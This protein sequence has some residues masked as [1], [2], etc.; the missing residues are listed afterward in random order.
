MDD[1]SSHP[2]VFSSGM[3]LP[4]VSAD[5]CSIAASTAE[6]SMREVTQSAAD[7]YGKEIVCSQNDTDPSPVT[8]LTAVYRTTSLIRIEWTA[9]NDSRAFEYTYSIL[10][11]GLTSNLTRTN[12]TSPNTTAFNVTG[13]D[14]GDRYKLS[15]E[16]VTPENKTSSPREVTSTTNPSPVTGLTAVYRTINLI[17]VEWTAPND[18]R[19]FE[20][21]YRIHVTWLTNNAT[22]TNSTSPNTTAFNVTGLDPGDR[23]KLS[24]ESVTPENTT[25]SPKEVTSTTNP[26]PITGLTEVYRTTSLI[27]IEWTAPNDSRA[28]EYTY[29]ILVTGLTNNATWIQSTSP[30]TTTFNMTGLDPG[31]RYKLS[32]ESVTPENTTSSPKEVTSTTNPSPVSRLFVVNRTANSIQIKWTAPTDSRASDYKYR[33]TVA[34][35]A[36]GIN[37]TNYTSQDVTAFTV[38]NL[39]PGIQYKLSVESVTPESTL[40]TPEE[41]TN[42]TNPSPV[43]GLSLVNRTTNSLG[44]KWTAPTDT[45]ASDY[46]YKITVASVAGGDSR[47]NYTSQ[48]MTVF[49]VTNLDPGIQYKLSVESVTPESTLSIPEEVTNTTNPSP[50]F[51]LSL[52]NRTTNSLGIKWTAPT[53]T[54]ASDYKYKITVASVA[55]GDSRTNY[56]SQDMTVFTV[57]NLDPGIQYKLSVESVTPESTL[58]IPEEVTN[59]TNPSPV[60][61][62]SLVNRTTNSLGIKWTAPTDTRASDYKYKITVAS[63][64]GGDSRTNYT[65]QDMTVFTV[66]NLDPGIQYKLSVESVTP[67]STL[68]IPE[69]VT[70]TTNPSPVSS[71]SVV[72]RTTNSIQIKWTAPTDS[73]ASDYK[74]RISVASIAVEDSIT[75]YTSQDVTVFTMTNLDPGIQY[76]LSV[77]S[78]TPE[79]TLS[80]PEEVTNTT[81]PSP[82]F[83]LSLVNRTTNSLGIKWTAPTDTRASDYKYKITVAS[84]A[85]GDSRTNYTSQDMTVFTVTN[86]DPGIQYKLSVESVTPES[87]LSIP[88]EVTNTTNPSPVSSLSVVNRTTN[89]IQ[90]KWTAPTD[91]RASDYKYRI[92]VASIAVEDSITNYTSQDVTVFTMTNLDPGIQYKLSVESVTPESTLSIPEEVTNTTIPGIVANFHCAGKTGYTITVK[93][94]KPKGNFTSF[95]VLIYDIDKLLKNTTIGKDKSEL[96]VKQLQPGRKYIV[97]I[98]TETRQE[99]SEQVTEQCWTN[100]QPIIVGATVGSLLGLILIGILLSFIIHKSRQGK[101]SKQRDPGLSSMHSFPSSFKPIPVDEYKSYFQR[102]HADTDIGFAEEY[103]SLATVGVDQSKEAFLHADNKVKNRYTNIFPYDATRVKLNSQ[104]DSSSS[105]YINASYMPGYNTENAFIAA[106]GPLPSTVADF[107][108]MIWEQ[109]TQV[110]VMLTNC[111]EQNRVKCEH[112]WPMDYNTCIYG[113][114]AVNIVSENI[115]PEWTIRNFKIK[116]VGDSKSRKVTHFHFTSW[117]DH[118][119]PEDTEKLLQFQKLIRN[120]LN[121]SQGGCPVIHCSAGVG[122]TGTL[123]AL[124][125]LLQRMDKEAMVDVYG[126]VYK[127]RMNRTCMVQTEPQYIFLHRCILDTIQT[128]YNKEP[129]YQNQIDLIYENVSAIKAANNHRV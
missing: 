100:S 79:S 103:Q 93:W 1:S 108:R 3:L 14:P 17:E 90:I 42:T 24:V 59:T 13:L 57:T 31:D 129:I 128:R 127:M 8:G 9:P 69:E 4:P 64:A 21:T 51:G 97:K 67:E 11:T 77:E 89:S 63:V 126:I 96:T 87:T 95:K 46:K 91:S 65:S 7:F 10:V 125:Y 121:N 23:Y 15:V 53:D 70:N 61:G 116:K 37:R 40:S 76:K 41:V 119:V 85:G 122:R 75:N 66:T 113:D 27:R 36:G 74:Y 109:E 81:N 54:R 39:D 68:S 114:I 83:G 2:D 112:Y 106:Q 52:V 80:I 34:S 33:I 38:T 29:S 56:T 104:P 84:V 45:R 115:S 71:L 102:M 32:V 88:E 86:L 55:G 105:D 22:W 118:G 107:W 30:N 5:F 50:V 6:R 58:S 123:I 73:R 43:F 18:S 12:S 47:T 101:G 92:S 35:V 94:N 26:S 20:Y 28:F 99:V 19:T 44:I 124:D 48:D 72:N 120:H 25:S 16:S 62:L 117:P 49:T 78:V 98:S 111:V 110:I 82:V 60:F